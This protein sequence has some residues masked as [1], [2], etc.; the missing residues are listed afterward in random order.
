MSSNIRSHIKAYD[1]KCEPYLWSC[2][3]LWAI[4][5]L[6]HLAALS[7]P[8][9]HRRDQRRRCPMADAR[10]DAAPNIIRFI[11]PQRAHTSLSLRGLLQ[12]G[13]G[14]HYYLFFPTLWRGFGNYPFTLAC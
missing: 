13:P 7:Y 9:R 14:V 10:Y 1:S 4:G 2:V 3:A 12:P 8:F 11:V 5:R 6:L